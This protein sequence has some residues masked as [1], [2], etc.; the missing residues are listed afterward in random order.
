MNTNRLTKQFSLNE[1]TYYTDLEAE[2]DNQKI[3]HYCFMGGNEVKLEKDFYN[4][5]PYSKITPDEFMGY[6]YD[7]GLYRIPY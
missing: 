2:E 5:S 6:L 4:H 1:Y 7:A 3:Y